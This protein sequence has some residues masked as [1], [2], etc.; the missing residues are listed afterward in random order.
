MLES[1]LQAVG[2]L[3]HINLTF[4]L[5]SEKEALWVFGIDH[6]Q[7]VSD[8]WEAVHALQHCK[9]P[10]LWLEIDSVTDVAF[11]LKQTLRQENYIPTQIFISIGRLDILSTSTAV[12]REQFETMVQNCICVI[13]KSPRKRCVAKMIIA[14]IQ[15]QLIY[16]TYNKQAA[17]RKKLNGINRKI[18]ALAASNACLVTPSSGITGDQKY[19]LTD[20]DHCLSPLAVELLAHSW[21]LAV[22][23]N[24]Q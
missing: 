11:A 9:G 6:V 4:A 10:L 24:K 21:M 7:Q 14:P 17:A 18:N 13:D 15:H 22:D 5:I 8:H 19:F 3:I 1:K 2:S 23:S 12:L 20:S 16:P